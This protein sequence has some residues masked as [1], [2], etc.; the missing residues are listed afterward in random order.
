MPSVTRLGD[1]STG[2]GSYIPTNTTSA[3]SNVFVNG[4]GV[5]K[6]GDSYA[7][8]GSP[9]P[10]PAHG[11]SASGGSGSVYVNGQPIH[12][13]GDSISCGDTSAQGSSNVF[14]GG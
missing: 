9:S 10:S 6:V 8:H 13:I 14:A 1:L 7:P 5:V 11:R 4:I 12:R 3:S 2:H